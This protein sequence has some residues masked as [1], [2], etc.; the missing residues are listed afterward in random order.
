MH[1][2]QKNIIVSLVAYSE[3][4]LKQLLTE[5]YRVYQ[6]APGVFE[7]RYS[8]KDLRQLGYEDVAHYRAEKISTCGVKHQIRHMQ[9]K[10]KLRIWLDDNVFH[11]LLKYHHVRNLIL[12]NDSRID[13]A[14]FEMTT[15]DEQLMPRVGETISFDEANIVE[16]IN[17]FELT[18]VSIALQIN[19]K[20]NRDNWLYDL[21]NDL[22][23][24]HLRSARWVQAEVIMSLH[25]SETR[26]KESQKQKALFGYWLSLKM[27]N[28]LSEVRRAIEKFNV[29]NLGFRG[30]LIKHALLDRFDE[31]LE[32]LPAALKS[33]EIAPD[34]IMNNPILKTVRE[35]KRV[36]DIIGR[37]AG[38]EPISPWSKI[39]SSL[40]HVFEKLSLFREL[41]SKISLACKNNLSG[42][43]LKSIGGK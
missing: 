15:S 38:D 33:R 10:L 29:S 2:L 39:R 43:V 24:S 25:L 35:D 13:Q 14:L 37:K 3:T 23:Y 12:H 18:Y 11:E 41:N 32:I 22:A 19:R 5:Y 40:K 27:Q 28:R 34:E 20:I 16:I 6:R 30:V 7:D 4:F 36:R 26:L 17:I 21:I 8:Q 31:F 42:G 1:Q 9:S